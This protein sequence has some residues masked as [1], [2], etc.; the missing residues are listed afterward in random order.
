[1]LE[2]IKVAIELLSKSINPSAISEWRRKEK[3]QEIGARLFLLY[4][5]LNEV[6]LTGEDILDE[7][8]RKGSLASKE[9]QGEQEEDEPIRRRRIRRLLKQQAENFEYVY[10]QLYLLRPQLVVAIDDESDYS[11]HRLL[12]NKFRRLAVVCELI[13]D[14]R[15]PPHNLLSG[16]SIVEESL[17][18]SVPW[19]AETYA[20]IEKHV[21]EGRKGIEDVR[22]ALGQLRTSL[23]ETFSVQDIL[24]GVGDEKFRELRV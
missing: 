8:D 14:D 10:D 1:M 21:S 24:L 12:G 4:M 17:S 22:V 20:K 16:F 9:G 2:A 19:T 15:I 11:L 3:L 18:C 5:M 7:L 6:L 13:E 23:K